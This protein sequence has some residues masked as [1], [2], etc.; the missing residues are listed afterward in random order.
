MDQLPQYRTKLCR[1]GALCRHLLR[2]NCTFAHTTEEMRAY[3]NPW[4]NAKYSV[5]TFVDNDIANHASFEYKDGTIEH[6]VQQ[7]QSRTDTPHHIWCKDSLLFLKYE[8]DA[9]ALVG[10]PEQENHAV[11]VDNKIFTSHDATVPTE[12]TQIE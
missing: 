4:A 8:G 11:L 6:F 12:S 2:G 7:V 3:F 10:L 1:H 5:I 9:L